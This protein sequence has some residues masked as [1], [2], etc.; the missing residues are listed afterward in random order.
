MTS[1]DAT[2][3]QIPAW[4]TEIRRLE[5]EARVAF[6]DADVAALH[7]L[8]ADGYAVNSPLERINDKG[9][10]LGLLQAGR[11]QHATYDCR[12]ELIH[13]HGDVVVVMGEDHVTG[14]PAG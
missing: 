3:P 1:T 11:I 6:L 10:V 4:E 2:A 7:R 5:E 14:P 13:R 9:Q 8:W 12:I